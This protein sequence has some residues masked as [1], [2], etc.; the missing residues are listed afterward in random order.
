MRL[1]F[2]LYFENS[3]K[4]FLWIFCCVFI[5]WVYLTTGWSNS[6]IHLIFLYRFC[7]FCSTYELV[8][9]QCFRWVNLLFLHSLWIV[10]WCYG[11]G[12]ETKREVQG[13]TIERL[14]SCEFA[15][16]FN[17]VVFK[18][19]SR[20]FC[21]WSELAGVFFRPEQDAVFVFRERAFGRQGECDR[22]GAVSS[23][24]VRVCVSEFCIVVLS[25]FGF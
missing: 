15:D 10:A 2:S 21:G 9:N 20:N 3:A 16:V 12:F 22:Y 8:W 4:S 6:V 19:V 5:F 14:Q 13:I 17:D 18:T 24:E 23:S 11:D 1:W 25:L 7:V